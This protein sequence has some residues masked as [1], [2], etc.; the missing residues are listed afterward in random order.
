MVKKK[1]ML[2]LAAAAALFFLAGSGFAQDYLEL[3]RSDIRTMKVAVVTE[4]MQLTAEESDKFWPIYRE[5]EAE[6]ANN[7]DRRIALIRDYARNY[8]TMTDEKARQL[9]QDLISIDKGRANLWRKYYYRVERALS[10]PVAARFVQVERQIGLLIDL[11][12]ASE[13]P[14]ISKP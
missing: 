12:I 9:T 4:A 14:L 13:M 7:Y 3:L 5:Y 10:A 8:T 1:T 2:M 11:Q 6:L